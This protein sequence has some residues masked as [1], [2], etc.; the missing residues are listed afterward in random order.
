MSLSA[1][2]TATFSASLRLC[3]IALLISILP[4]ILV[5]AAAEPHR[6][7]YLIVGVLGSVAGGWGTSRPLDL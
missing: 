1:T 3:W 7:Q 4:T 2:L 5:M 6:L